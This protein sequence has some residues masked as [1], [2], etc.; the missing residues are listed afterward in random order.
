[1]G[2]EGAIGPKDVADVQLEANADTREKIG[3]YREEDDV[4]PLVADVSPSPSGYQSTTLNRGRWD[5][6]E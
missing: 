1:M 3:K 2:R 4:E 5:T 6:R